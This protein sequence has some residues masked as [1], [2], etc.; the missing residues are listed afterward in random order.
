MTV[1][2]PTG[3]GNFS[4]DLDCNDGNCT[5]LFYSR[6]IGRRPHRSVG[7]PEN[8]FATQPSNTTI[9]GAAKLTGRVGKF[10]IGALNAP[11]AYSG[12]PNFNYHSFR[13]TNVL[14]WEYRP[15]S[16]L[17]VV[18]Q[19]GREDSTPQG[20]FAFGRDFGRAFSTPGTNTFLVKFSRWFNF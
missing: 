18:W 9:L 15:G 8:G 20:D 3:S 7:A 17:F 13:T 19:Q 1:R 6:R 5:G 4:F 12:Q 16:T 11:F 10:S 2:R 14:R